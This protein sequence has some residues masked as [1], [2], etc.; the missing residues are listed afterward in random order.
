M[1]NNDDDEG[2]N[3]EEDDD[4][5][6]DMAPMELV[7]DDEGVQGGRLRRRRRRR[8]KRNERN[9][10]GGLVGLS[11]VVDAFQTFNK[12]VEIRKDLSP[13]DKAFKFENGT[14]PIVGLNVLRTPLKKYVN[15]GLNIL[16][17]GKFQDAVAKAGYD[18]MFHLFLMGRLQ[19]G[20]EF[21]L[22]KN[23]TVRLR[24]YS[25]SD[26]NSQTEL[27]SVNL[28]GKTI[29]N[30][31]LFDNA[32]N[33]EKDRFWAYDGLKN[34][35]QDFVL[36]VLGS[37]GLLNDE[38]KQFI[39]QNAQGIAEEIND[40]NPIASTIIRGTTDFASKMRRVFGLGLAV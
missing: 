13:A 28:A 22:E 34:N 8:N 40:R 12:A 36:S 38:L 31:S 26:V 33:N 20:V 6:D 9:E 7:E 19:N 21:I 29:T 4:F 25:K 35:C 17:L 11:N 32:I 24:P 30:D 3:I 10:Q 23:E 18:N 2:N 37:S 16:T 14:Q 15:A 1:N 27:K 5:F 39:K